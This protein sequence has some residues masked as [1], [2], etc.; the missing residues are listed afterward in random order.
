MPSRLRMI[1]YVAIA[2]WRKY[3]HSQIV[4]A[5][6]ALVRYHAIVQ[7]FPTRSVSLVASLSTGIIKR[8][9]NRE[10]I[11]KPFAVRAYPI[12]SQVPWSTEYFTYDNS[13]VPSKYGE[14]VK[15]SYQIPARS[16]VAGY[17]DRKSEDG[18]WVHESPPIAGASLAV[19]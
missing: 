9:K 3:R 8:K 2:P 7:V 1:P 10:R 16:D 18:E 19:S 4:G 6:V 5:T 15:A 17:E 13:V 11:A 12:I 14:L